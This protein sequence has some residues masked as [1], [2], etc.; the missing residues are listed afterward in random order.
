MT[1]RVL[2]QEAES[3]IGDIRLIVVEYQRAQEL[4]RDNPPG[5]IPGHGHTPAQRAA[6]LALA[7][8]VS[9]AE[10]FSAEQLRAMPGAVE[11]N[12]SS[13]PKQQ[14]AWRKLGPVDLETLPSYPAVRGF[15]E[16][17]NAVLH[18][19][20]RLTA[21]QVEGAQNKQVQKWLKCAGARVV[22]GEVRVGEP[23]I[24]RCAHACC[25]FIRHLDAR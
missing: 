19:R 24:V 25:D 3:A 6:Q 2:S 5:R 7:N 18:G 1:R 22:R 17:R 21:R 4:V 23:D 15:N 20:G 10:L 13:W 14:Q 9:C 12:V 16:V 8:V 11:D